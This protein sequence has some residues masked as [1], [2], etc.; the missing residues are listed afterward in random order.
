MNYYKAGKQRDVRIAQLLGWKLEIIEKPF[1]SFWI[2]PDGE[3]V[4]PSDLPMWSEDSE[5]VQPLWEELPAPKTLYIDE[6]GKHTITWRGHPYRVSA[7][8]FAEAVSGAWILW[9]EMLA[10]PKTSVE[11]WC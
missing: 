5:E 3:R 11:V 10:D 7:N 4:D 2:T 9:K 1:S 8:S 6:D